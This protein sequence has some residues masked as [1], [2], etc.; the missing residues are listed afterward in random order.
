MKTVC[1]VIISFLLL[2]TCN[3]TSHSIQKGNMEIANE[4]IDAFYSFERDSLQVILDKTDESAKS[5]LYYQEWAECGNYQIKKRHYYFEKNDSVVICPVTVKDDLIGALGIDFN[6]T[7]TFHLTIVDGQI[8]SIQTSS[9]DPD[10]YYKAK[11]WVQQNRP[12]LIEKPCEG[13]WED[14]TT[15]CECVQAMVQGFKEFANQMEK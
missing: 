6:V 10:Q 11:E 5:I 8:R 2:L 3:N 1:V 4:F 12:E 14:G 13:I 7:D 9:N 15:P